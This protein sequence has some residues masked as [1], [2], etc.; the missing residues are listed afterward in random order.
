MHFFLI[1]GNHLGRTT[2]P[3]AV[4]KPGVNLSLLLILGG[5]TILEALEEKLMVLNCL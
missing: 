4:S 1:T 5:F 3:E 2:A